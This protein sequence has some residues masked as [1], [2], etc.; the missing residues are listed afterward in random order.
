MHT[1][2]TKQKKIREWRRRLQTAF[3][4]LCKRRRYTHTARAAAAPLTDAA[5]TFKM[6]NIIILIII[7]LYPPTHDKQHRPA[8]NT[9]IGSLRRLASCSYVRA[10][11]KHAFETGGDNNNET[12]RHGGVG[13]PTPLRSAPPDD[14][15]RKNGGGG[16]DGFFCAVVGGKM[17]AEK[18]TRALR[19]PRDSDN[20]KNTRKTRFF[21][22]RVRVINGTCGGTANVKTRRRSPPHI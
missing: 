13:V 15:L 16:N 4:N 1:E 6:Y 2:Q 3:S 9:L 20:N 10:R 17:T 21:N 5:G 22:G 14:S 7:P 18:S 19:Q 12:K 8:G 11:G